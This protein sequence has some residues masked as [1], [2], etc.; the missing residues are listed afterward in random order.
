M[1][2]RAPLIWGGDPVKSNTSTLAL[3][4]N[5][6]VLDVQTESCRNVQLPTAAGAS[7]TSLVWVAQGTAANARY[8]AMFNLADT[9]AKA[10]LA[11]SAVGFGSPKG[12]KAMDLWTAKDVPLTSDGV[13]CRLE[14]HGSCLLKLVK[15]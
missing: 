9:P 3:L 13:E 14:A 10:S 6:H 4:D 5:Q 2:A 11:L 8:A 7:V 1:I 12:I 15:S